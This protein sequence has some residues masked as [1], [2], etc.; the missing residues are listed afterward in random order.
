MSKQKKP[1][2]F[3][4]QSLGVPNRYKVARH[5]FKKVRGAKGRT[6]EEAKLERLLDFVDQYFNNHWAGKYTSLDET[7]RLKRG[8]DVR[9]MTYLELNRRLEIVRRV[10]QVMEEK[11]LKKTPA[12]RE[13]AKDLGIPIGTI[14]EYYENLANV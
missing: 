1:P 12:M 9:K 14:T 3:T 8:G 5:L 7:L 4:P 11:N 6:D 13:V 2:P 10:I